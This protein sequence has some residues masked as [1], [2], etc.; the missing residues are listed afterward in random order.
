MVAQF[1]LHHQQAGSTSHHHKKSASTATKEAKDTKEEEKKDAKTDAN[2]WLPTAADWTLILKGARTTTFKKD[3]MVMKEGEATT[4]VFQLVAGECRFEKVFEGESRVL[5]KMSLSEGSTTDNMFGEI[6]FLEGGKASASVVCNKDD[7]SIAIIED[8]WLDVVF[9]YY[10]EIAGKFYHYLA[11]VLSKRL[12]QRET[13]PAAAAAPAAASSA[14]GGSGE[15][16]AEELS[17]SSKKKRDKKKDKK[18]KSHSKRKSDTRPN[19]EEAA[20]ATTED[21]E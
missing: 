7:T 10:P 21:E 12:K 16:P 15:A 18:E 9:S 4:R 20:D 6:S 17:S 19:D 14:Q 1:R 11:N 2:P 5:G 3:D 8:Y 13:A